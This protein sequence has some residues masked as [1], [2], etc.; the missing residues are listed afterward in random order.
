MPE[1]GVSSLV[2]LLVIHGP[3]GIVAGIFIFLFIKRDIELAAERKARIDDAAK[4]LDRILALQREYHDD[5][6]VF[7]RVASE[8][9]DLLPPRRPR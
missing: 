8:L 9:K 2:S 1:A 5:A 3:I 6:E 4:V 7:A